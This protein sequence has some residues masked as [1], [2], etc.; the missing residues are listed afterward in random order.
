[1]I[2]VCEKQAA[3]SMGKIGE[4]QEKRRIIK[5]KERKSHGKKKQ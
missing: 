1:M 5:K 3:F 2:A 4:N